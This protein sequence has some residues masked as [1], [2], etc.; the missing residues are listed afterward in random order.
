[1]KKFIR[2]SIVFMGIIVLISCSKSPLEDIELQDVSLLT[3]KIIIKE[4]RTYNISVAENGTSK[5]EVYVKIRDK[6]NRA[7]KLLNGKVRVQ[8]QLCE[9]GKPDPLLTRDTYYV[10]K[11]VSGDGD[12]DYKVEVEL[13]NGNVHL[14]TIGVP[15]FFD[16][17]IIV[18]TKNYR[19]TWPK[20]RKSEKLYLAMSFEDENGS[21]TVY[22][23]ANFV[24]DIGVFDYANIAN[25]LVK[26]ANNTYSKL[27]IRLFRRI[28]GKLEANG[29]RKDTKYTIEMT[30]NVEIFGKP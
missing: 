11:F 2:S 23:P 9:F 6:N 12:A 4:H 14:T 17:K 8:G 20:T 21:H 10:K 18:D 25:T 7:V 16:S 19:I 26:L 5:K 29:F 30:H 28:E 13:F 1:M 24:P 3:Q 27:N 22:G 15:A